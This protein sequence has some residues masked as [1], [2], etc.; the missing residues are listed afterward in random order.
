MC[1]CHLIVQIPRG[2]EQSRDV[3]AHA[4]IRSRASIVLL[5]HK[6]KCKITDKETIKCKFKPYIVYR[7]LL[8][9]IH[10]YM[11]VCHWSCFVVKCYL[12][13]SQIFLLHS[14]TIPKVHTFHSTCKCVKGL[15]LYTLL[16]F[17]SIYML[18]SSFIVL[19]KPKIK[20]FCDRNLIDCMYTTQNR[21][22]IYPIG[23]H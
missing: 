16:Y 4:Q 3:L 22:C 13:V 8:I 1:I 17:L 23:L 11:A 2:A 18:K 19:I 5:K 20:S 21:V 15:T 14:Y 9:N 12:Y 7:K 10:I 6:S